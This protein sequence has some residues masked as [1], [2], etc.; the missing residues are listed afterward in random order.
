MNRY[1]APKSIQCRNCKEHGHMSRDCP[2][3]MKRRCAFCAEEGHPHQAC[4][5]AFCF[6]CNGP[7]HRVKD[8]TN[9]RQNTRDPCPRCWVTGHKDNMCPDLWRQCRTSV[10]A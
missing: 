8:C 9:P 1:F 10:T 3:P 7:G 4:P 2:E 6:K 5:G